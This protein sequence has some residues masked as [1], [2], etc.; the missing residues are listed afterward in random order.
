MSQSV[1]HSTPFS[2]WMALGLLIIAAILNF[3]DRQILS[4]LVGPIKSHFGL[5]DVQIGL[6]QGPAFALLYAL[7]AF[8]FG[9]AVDRL[10][11]RYVLAFGV[12][13]WSLMTMLCGLARNFFELALARM[14]VGITEASLGPSAHSII[15]DSFDRTRLPLAMSLYGMATSLGSGFAFVL[16]GQVVAATERIGDV[17]V[18]VYGIM[19]SWK[20]AFLV[21]GFP[22]IVLAATIVVFLKEPA[23]SAT[24]AAAAAPHSDSLIV[25]FKQR[26]WLSLAGL[27]AIGLKT[28][29]GY[30]I[31]SWTPTFFQRI[32]GWTAAEAGL[33]IG[34]L[35]LM[36][37][38]PGSILAGSLTSALVR[39][40]IRDASLLVIAIT[41][42]ASAPFMAAA[43]IVQDPTLTLALLV[44]PNLLNPAYI[45]LWPALI[46]AVTPSTLRGRVSAVSMLVTTLVGM[47]FGPMAVAYLTDAVFADLAAVGMSLSITT[48]TFSVAGALLLL[49]TR[50]S[51]FQAIEL[52]ATD[53]G[54]QSGELR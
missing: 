7:S 30:A 46:Q 9:M 32:H 41:T 1:E 5:S 44:V 33:A 17:A 24:Q 29:S 40:G 12:A 11:R 28:A 2:S 35:V 16:G 10:D 45:G 34:T 26:K 31:L 18:P 42:L 36:F 19:E 47:S 37:G 43:F 23:R 14:G 27:I 53:G 48:A 13:G 39:R 25:F 50:K 20:L 21:V 52:A 8:P 15:G 22:G 51:Y 38:V 4:L 6:L 54:Q 3:V 49:T